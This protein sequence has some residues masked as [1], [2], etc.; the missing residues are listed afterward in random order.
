L[1]SAAPARYVLLSKEG[2]LVARR[3]MRALAMRALA[4]RAL[5]VRALAVLALAVLASGGLLACGS[6]GSGPGSSPGVVADP[7]SVSIDVAADRHPISPDVYGATLW[8]EY[9]C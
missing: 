1:T 9:N 8:Y 5:A 7:V 6:G 2:D 3:A 4:V